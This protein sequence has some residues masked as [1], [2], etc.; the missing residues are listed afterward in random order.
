MQIFIFFTSNL[1]HARFVMEVSCCFDNY[2][3]EVKG[4]TVSSE[5]PT[6]I[7]TLI[8]ITFSA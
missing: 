6:T 7:I 1:F 4:A 3:S 5:K 8:I 2:F